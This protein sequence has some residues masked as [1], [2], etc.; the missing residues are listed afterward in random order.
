[1]EKQVRLVPLH[2]GFDRLKTKHLR[3]AMIAFMPS[4][5]VRITVQRY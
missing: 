2:S 4:Q 5:P 3:A 1:M